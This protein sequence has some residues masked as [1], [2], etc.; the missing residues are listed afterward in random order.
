MKQGH[1]LSR[2]KRETLT[3]ASTWDGQP[4]AERDWVYVTLECGRQDLRIDVDA[5]FHGDPAPLGPPASTEGLWR[6]EV[7]EVFVASDAEESGSVRYT[8]IE[9]SPHGHYLV[10]RFE[11]IRRRVAEGLPLRFQCGRR[12]DRWHGTAFLDRRHLP[13]SP[14]RVNVYAICGEGRARRHLAAIPVPGSRPDFHQPRAFKRL[15][16]SLFP[17][18]R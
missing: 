13:D 15:P 8:E 1:A 7:I 5:P 2:E 10:L 9:L 6:Y 12:G 18:D 3:V 11:G 17:T 4:L 14:Q 16:R